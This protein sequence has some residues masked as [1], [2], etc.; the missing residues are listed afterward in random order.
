MNPYPKKLEVVEDFCPICLTQFIEKDLDG[1]KHFMPNH[2][3]FQIKMSN[4]SFTD[5]AVCKTCFKER[6]SREMI[7]AIFEGLK[8]YWLKAGAKD[9]DLLDGSRKIEKIYRN[10]VW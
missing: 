2:C 7:D 9:K 10:T 3:Q 5:I 1:N 6:A 4:G 8:E